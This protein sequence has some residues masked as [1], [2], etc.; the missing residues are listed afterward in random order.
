MYDVTRPTH[1][2]AKQPATPP[3]KNH[4]PLTVWGDQRGLFTPR[5]LKVGGNTEQRSRPLIQGSA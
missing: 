4:P 2:N 3:V 5:G 1:P